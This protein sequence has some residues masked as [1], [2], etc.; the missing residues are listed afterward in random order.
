MKKYRYKKGLFGMSADPIT[1]GHIDIIRKSLEQCEN[2]IVL[3]ANNTQKRDY[4]FSLDERV[5]MV[6]AAIAVQFPE[7]RDRIT[8]LETTGLLVDVYLRENCDVIIRGVRHLHDESR[9]NEQR[10][11]YT[12]MHPELA[13]RFLYIQSTEALMV[14][15]SSWVKDLTRLFVNIAPLV[16]LSVKAALEQ[17]ALNQVLVGVTGPMGNGKSFV[18]EQ[19]IADLQAQN[20]PASVIAVDALV[21]ELYRED[22]LGA[23]A[24]REQI[25]EKFGATVLSSDRKEV[26]RM[27]LRTEL[28][29]GNPATAVE[30]ILWIQALTRPHVERLFRAARTERVGILFLEWADYVHIN[31]LPWVNNTVIVVEADEAIAV[32]RLF[33]N[34]NIPKEYATVV[35]NFQ[36]SQEEMITDANQQILK[37]GYGHC[38]KIETNR[39]ALDPFTVRSIVD[40]LSELYTPVT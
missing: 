32:R 24:I 23:Q 33:D 19:L 8:V 14:V 21:D 11:L 4:L 31:L 34:R 35:R 18:I 25:A 39:N 22:S 30:N 29:R 36:R 27:A 12:M 1:V 7:A 28:F 3:V 13:D 37:A 15:S 17:R 40:Q 38:L 5:Q 20:I 26:N 2:V 6:R 9:E 10:A 16:P